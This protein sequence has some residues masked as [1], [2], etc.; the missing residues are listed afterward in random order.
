MNGYDLK[1][2][3]LKMF[4]PG[5]KRGGSPWVSFIFWVSVCG[6]RVERIVDLR[7]CVCV[8]V[9]KGWGA[10]GG[11]R[12]TWAGGGAARGSVLLVSE[13]TGGFTQSGQIHAPREGGKKR[14]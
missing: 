2:N 9:S 7:V 4:F 5:S 1:Q 10:T 14:G 13:V 6:E 11:T 3:L 12:R 8:C